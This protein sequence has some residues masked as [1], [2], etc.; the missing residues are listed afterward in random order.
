VFLTA[1]FAFFIF[2]TAFNAFNVRTPNTF[3]VFHH[4]FEN[5]G[6]LTVMVLIFA[7]QVTFTY[8]GG[9]FLRTVGLTPNEWFMVIG[10]SSV[11]VP[12]DLLRKFVMKTIFPPK[13][14][15]YRVKEN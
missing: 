3:N 11:I 6:F 13:R 9:R 12:F 10:A 14:T 2:L 7:V 5:S 4:I 1:F 8:V 15:E